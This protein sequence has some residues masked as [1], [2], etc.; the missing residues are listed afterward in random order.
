MRRYRLPFV[1]AIAVMAIV[2]LGTALA[3]ETF[4]HT[5]DGCAV[6]IHCLACRL[7]V[8]ST[9]VVGHALPC[10]RVLSVVGYVQRPPDTIVDSVVRS[11]APSRAPP[12]A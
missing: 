6:E 2:C 12:S 5:D 10:P 1:A 11:Q 7:A 4:V 8:G 3:A 9:A